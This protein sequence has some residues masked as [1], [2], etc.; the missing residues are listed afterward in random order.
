MASK[1]QA[2]KLLESIPKGG[3]LASDSG[4]VRVTPMAGGGF[5]WLSGKVETEV[6]HETA[7]KRLAWY[8]PEALAKVRAYTAEEGTVKSF[9]EKLRAD[10][11]LSELGVR[12][13]KS[14]AAK[15][16][17]AVEA[18]EGFKVGVGA[19]LVPGDQVVTDPGRGPERVV[20]V[21]SGGVSRGRVYLKLMLEP[22]KEPGGERR[23]RF[24]SPRKKYPLK[25][26]AMA[27]AGNTGENLA[28]AE[29]AKRV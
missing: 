18:P 28:D 15:K 16:S 24:I 26:A 12:S 13:P 29:H 20:S 22:I 23:R 4:G 7:V 14:G 1:E 27:K 25:K 19:D 2:K 21:G 6:D 5:R 9:E 10:E 3:Y 11:T 8:K 17:K